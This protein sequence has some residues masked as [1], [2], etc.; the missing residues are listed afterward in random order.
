MKGLTWLAC[1]GLVLWL[2]PLAAQDTT[3][4]TDDSQLREF[5]NSLQTWHAEFEQHQFDE[6]GELLERSDGEVDIRRPGRFRWQYQTPYRQLIVADGERIWIY[7]QDL[8][9]VTVKDF[10]AGLGNTPAMLLSSGRDWERAFEIEALPR[11]DEEFRHYQLTPREKD[12]QFKQ[13]TLTFAGEALHQLELRD[14]L[15][16]ITL[17]R[18]SAQQRNPVL[19][20]DLFQFEP[21]EGVD[22]LDGRE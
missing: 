8:E 11:R 10:S 5:L 16:Q 1:F 12:A 18:F 20:P 4:P 22:I 9:Q 7:D 21:P 17:I 19:A 15:G 13:M 14:N 2:S 6:S 3:P